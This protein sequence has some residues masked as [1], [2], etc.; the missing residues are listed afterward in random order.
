MI[1]PASVTFAQIGA[2]STRLG[3][4]S[5]RLW[6]CRRRVARGHVGRRD[7]VDRSCWLWD[8]EQVS[9]FYATSELARHY[10]VHCSGRRDLGFYVELA[11]RLD[12]GVVAD[13]GAG[14]GMLCSL[15]ASRGH[16][17]I[18]LEP[19]ATMLEIARRQPYADR[20]TWLHGTAAALPDSQAHLVVMTGHVAQYFLDDASWLDVLRHA[21]RALQPNGHVAFE[22]RNK[23][24]EAWRDWQFTEPRRV[25]GGSLRQD[26]LVDGDLVTHVGR[27]SVDGREFVTSETLRFPSWED[28]ERGLAGVGLHQVETWG[29][30]DGS[31]VSST[32]PEWIVL[33]ARD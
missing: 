2:A 5:G 16:H 21:R 8:A 20:V 7:C 15:L 33:A 9:N 27:W 18:G 4:T 19:Q 24:V 26:V 14:T 3:L 28:V 13:I 25:D 31:P 22:V 10:D 6:E 23:E 29:D 30:W 17:V 12:A 11:A 32:A 1:K